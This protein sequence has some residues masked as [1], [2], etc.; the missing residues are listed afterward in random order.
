MS[1]TRIYSVTH[2]LSLEYDLISKK[3]ANMLSGTNTDAGV[4]FLGF[5]LIS[6][7]ISG[8]LQSFDMGVAVEGLQFVN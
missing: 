1:S 7:K 4:F 2:K 5:S 8:Q 3:R 6:S